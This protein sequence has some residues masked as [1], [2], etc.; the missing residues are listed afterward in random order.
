MVTG[1][2]AGTL[3]GASISISDVGKS[4][5]EDLALSVALGTD[6]Y[7]VT[8]I[9]SRNA[10]SGDD[11]YGQYLTVAG[12]PIDANFAVNTEAG[13]QFNPY[14]MGNS[15]D[16]SF[17]AGWGYKVGASVNHLNS[18]ILNAPVTPGGGSGGGGGG[19]GCFISSV[20]GGWQ[21]L[22]WALSG[23]LAAVGIRRR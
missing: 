23:L 11:I 22:A 21:V 15:N 7:L 6:R 10:S 5:D 4:V 3:N 2:G 1:S 8:W 18:T 13:G 14:V 12:Q 16:G 20:G 17:L 19:G 9:D